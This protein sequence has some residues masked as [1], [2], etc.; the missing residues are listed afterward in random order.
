[1]DTTLTARAVFFV[2]CADR[3]RDRTCQK[4]KGQSL[5]LLE[6]HGYPEMLP[7]VGAEEVREMLEDTMLSSCGGM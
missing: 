5:F 3:G 4:P 6:Y 2:A 7:I 1:M